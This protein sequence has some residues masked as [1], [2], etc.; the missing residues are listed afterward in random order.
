MDDTTNL[1][2]GYNLIS[3]SSLDSTNDEALRLL[4]GNHT[5]LDKSVI[6]AAE[7]TAAR[8]RRGRSWS[9]PL[10]NL[11]CSLILTPRVE[12]AD[13]PQLGY[14]AAL[15]IVQVLKE[16]CPAGCDVACKWPNDVLINGRK[17]SGVL[18]ETSHEAHVTHASANVSANAANVS[19]NAIVV[20]VGINISSFPQNTPYK[21]TS[22]NQEGASDLS[23]PLV[24]ARFIH[25][26]DYWLVAWQSRGFGPLRNAWLACA[27]GL[28][29]KILVRLENQ[30]LSGIFKG[31]DQS[32][33]LILQQD[34]ND[35]QRLITVGDVFFPD[36]SC[37]GNTDNASRH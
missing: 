21:A 29:Q 26:F 11:Y 25:H 31:I 23:P 35:K 32:G 30:E 17:V 7:Q 6:C 37:S 10:G 3:Y 18:L 9:A 13:L 15:A 2:H 1:P 4:A 12:I 34:G 5:S 33:A 14:V 36:P 24:L 22:M 27:A 20:G 16:L 8:G 19:A 28:Q